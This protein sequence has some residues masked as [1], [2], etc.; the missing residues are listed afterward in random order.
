MQ[1]KKKILLFTDWF[2]PGFKAGGPIRSCV[3]FVSHMQ[4]DY[5]IDVFTSDRDLGAKEP[6]AGVEPDRWLSKD[7]A[8]VRIY[9]LSPSQSAWT[10]IRRQ[11]KEI[12]P[13]FI[14]LNSMFSTYYTIYPLLLY[15][16]LGLKGRIVL[17]PRGMLRDSALQF[18]P[19]KKRLF[20]SIFRNSGLPG[21]ISFQAADGT[22][23]ED[24]KRSFGGSVQVAQIA[25]FP[26]A[27]PDQP[28][29]IEKRP[30]ELEL[31]FIGRIHPIKNLDYLLEVLNEVSCKIR[32]TI[33]G[34]I[35]EPS[36]WEKCREIIRLLPS[37]VSVNYAGEV[38]HH[39]LTPIIA[40]HHIF[41]L[42][43]RGENFGH[44]IFEALSLGRPVL[45]S[46]Q[47][48]WRCLTAAKAGWDL[49]L[50]EPG[51]FRKC[52]GEAGRFDQEEFDEWCRSA[53]T[54]A[55]T[56]IRRSDIKQQYLE[57]FR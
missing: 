1:Q 40:R 38:P 56:F 28:N 54:F 25:N 15:R 8:D 4:T 2:E 39:E 10:T 13:D 30:G 19:A 47:T 29:R 41:A 32:L 23:M 21:K 24:I 26:P 46:D 31:L 33:V 5:R 7:A 42:P 27:F 37:N 34:S 35:E 50:N 11:L 52:I 22:E 36:Y 16:L 20:L 43:T 6:Y 12:D 9:Y 18:K 3:N 49:P 44:A 51:L 57:L 48:P 55:Q 45:I 53:R 14:Y 17:S